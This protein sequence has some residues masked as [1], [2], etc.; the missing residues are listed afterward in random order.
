[1]YRVNHG[2]LKILRQPFQTSTYSKQIRFRQR[3]KERGIGMYQI[4][5]QVLFAG[6]HEPDLIL[7][8]VWANEP[9]GNDLFVLADAMR[10]VYGLV[11]HRRVPPWVYQI[12][13]VGLRKV[14]TR[15]TRLETDEEDFHLGVV[16]KGID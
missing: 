16:L 1:M 5:G 2:V 6:L 13:I 10:A 3:F 9:D 7:H 15:T 8:G 11:F 14:E 12:Y 4:L